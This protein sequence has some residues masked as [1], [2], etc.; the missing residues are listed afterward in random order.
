MDIAA[1]S[2]SLNQGK[3]QQ[4]AGLSVMKMAMRT[5]EQQGNTIISMAN[6]NTK[7]MALSVQPYLG[8]NLDI[9]A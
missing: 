5:A 4:Q 1:L 6:D 8:A 7:S 9:Q 2:I 3:L